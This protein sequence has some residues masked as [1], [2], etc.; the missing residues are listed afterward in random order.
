MVHKKFMLVINDLAEEY[1]SFLSPT[2]LIDTCKFNLKCTL[3]QRLVS[4]VC[5][6]FQLHENMRLECLVNSYLW[7]NYRGTI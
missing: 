5:V 4:H 1:G 6:Q 3:L 7:S 2:D